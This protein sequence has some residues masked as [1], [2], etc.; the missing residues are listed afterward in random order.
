MK[1]MLYAQFKLLLRR[2]ASFLLMTGICLLFAFFFGISSFG[3]STLPVYSEMSEKNTEIVMNYLQ[4]ADTQN[5]EQVEKEE[6]L[7]TVRE[8]DAE[9]G[10][11]LYEDHYEIVIASETPTKTILE[12]NIQKAFGDYLQKK[13]IHS[14]DVNDSAIMEQ[15]EDSMFSIETKTLTNEDSFVFDAQLQGI[16]GMSVFFVIYTVA[17]NV[18]QILVA[19]QDKIWDRFILSPVKKWEMYTGILTYAFIIGYI[20]V[21]LVF[22]V[23]KYGFDVDFYG[24]FL[25]SLILLIPYVLTI[26]SLS[27]LIVAVSKN[28]QT[29]NAIISL[30][31][32]SLAMIGGSYWPIEIV[33]NKA[34]LG[35][36]QIDPITYIMEALKNVTIYGQTLGETMFPISILLLMSVIMMGVG[37]N[38]MERR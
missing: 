28:Y 8:G 10:L 19:K 3:K 31:A 26:V 35:L 37:L 27:V 18:I 11:F 32:V 17:Y 15:L 30:V 4:E 20:Q 36:S 2:P 5:F 22:F 6:L 14:T 16:F 23:M 25:E 38:L 1:G 12:Q 29:F 9:A 7:K 34:M 33:T 13:R 21:V 24:G